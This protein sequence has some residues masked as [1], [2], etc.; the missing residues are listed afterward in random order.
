M[1]NESVLFH[2]GEIWYDVAQSGLESIK[3]VEGRFEAEGAAKRERLKREIKGLLEPIDAIMERG[4]DNV[5][6]IRQAFR[7]FLHSS[8]GWA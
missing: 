6:K 8:L 5:T 3:R 2:T 4:I 1:T 7:L